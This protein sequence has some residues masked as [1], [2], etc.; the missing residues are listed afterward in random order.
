MVMQ[1]KKGDNC[2]SK[3]S[4]EKLR[5]WRNENMSTPEQLEQKCTEYLL[6]FGGSR[7]LASY[8]EMGEKAGG[9]WI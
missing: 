5:F 1:G 6:A 4:H 9:W 8:Q 3:G 7:D 2:L